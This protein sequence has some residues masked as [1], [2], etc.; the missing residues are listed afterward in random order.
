MI[1]LLL[2]LAA[3]PE[4]KTYDPVDG[5]SI[6]SRDVPGERVVE[7]KLT[8]KSKLSVE[9]LCESAAGPKVLDP[10]EPD[11]TLRRVIRETPEERVTY[12]QSSSPVFF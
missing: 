2:V 11:I 12:E 6:A 8:T 9:K 7:L 10:A 5:I 4:W 1:S 3:S